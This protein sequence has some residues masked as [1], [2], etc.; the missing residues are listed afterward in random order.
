M[1][2]KEEKKEA[3]ADAHVSRVK[4]RILELSEKIEADATSN[5]ADGTATGAEDS[6][7]KNLPESFTSV[8]VEGKAVEAADALDDYRS[9]FIPATTLALGRIGTGIL[10][11][12]KKLT[13]VTGE[14]KMGKNAVVRTVQE[15]ERSYPAVGGDKSEPIVKLG[16]IRTDVDIKGSQSSSGQLK[17]VREDITA[18]ANAS[19][20]K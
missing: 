10:A 3:K 1:S 2:K 17:A 6:F 7:Y 5:K 8:V 12:N 16:V 11:G 13:T 15:R 20:K 14:I 18:L 4:P 19:F 9:D